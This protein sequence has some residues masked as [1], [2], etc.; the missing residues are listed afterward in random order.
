M[1]NVKNG[2]EN[3]TILHQIHCKSPHFPKVKVIVI[4]LKEI[5]IVDLSFVDNLQSKIVL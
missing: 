5:G 2:F 4:D 1:K 3:E